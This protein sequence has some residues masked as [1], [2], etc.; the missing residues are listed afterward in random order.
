MLEARNLCVALGAG[1]LHRQVLNGLDVRIAMGR[2]TCVLGPNGAG[3][4]TLLKALAGVL[5]QGSGSAEVRGDVYLQ[6]RSLASL[7]LRQR[8][9]TVSWLAQGGPDYSANDLSAYDV[10]ML[11][12]L[13]HRGWLAAPSA[14]DHAAVEQALRRTHAWDW[15][16]RPLGALSGGERQRVLLAR[17]LAVQ[18][19]VL[20]MDEPIANLDPQHQADW[21]LLVRE[22]VQQGQTVVS[23]L[24]DVSLSLLA[25]DLVLLDQGQVRY[26][27]PSQ[28]DDARVALEALFDHR[29][30]IVRTEVGG[31]VALPA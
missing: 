24:H 2:W 29:L 4:S 19:K 14:Q 30:R 7:S 5:Q 6:G 28:S 1:R 17:L 3:K 25:D 11:G 22:L 15:R 13:P 31:W 26:A 21:L 16:D 10:A 27:G 23:V 9:Q 8:A 12:R 18:A 20:L